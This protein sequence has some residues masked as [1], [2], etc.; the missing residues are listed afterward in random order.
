MVLVTEVDGDRWHN[1]VA[2]TANVEIL[3][4]ATTAPEAGEGDPA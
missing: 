4:R 3:S 1:I 2:S